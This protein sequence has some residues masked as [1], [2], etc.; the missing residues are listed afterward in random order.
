MRG[1]SD[2][3]QRDWRVLRVAEAL[4]RRTRRQRK[5]P[6]P[7]LW[8]SNCARGDL[9]PRG[10]RHMPKFTKLTGGSTVTPGTREGTTPRIVTAEKI[11][12]M[13][14]GAR[15]DQTTGTVRVGKIASRHCRSI[16][17]CC[18]PLAVRLPSVRRCE[19]MHPKRVRRRHRRPPSRRSCRRLPRS[20]RSYRRCR[21]S[22]RCRQSL[23][24]RRR[25][26]LQRRPTGAF[27]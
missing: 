13:H 3:G 20:H 8:A 27:D 11:V 5:R 10:G 25:N 15:S 17:H 18:L 6:Q 22:L 16:Q 23:S 12:R 7:A 26:C 4:P 24:R 1:G 2:R 19:V 14:R 21:R 9:T